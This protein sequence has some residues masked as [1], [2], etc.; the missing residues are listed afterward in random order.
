MLSFRISASASVG[1][2][3]AFAQLAIAQAPR[4][5]LP[6]THKPVPTTPA[7]SPAD[8]MTRLYTIADDSM[9]GREV[10]TEYH[11]KATAYIAAEA[12]RMGLVPAGD[13]GGY[14]QNLPV[15]S[16][17]SDSASMLGVGAERLANGPDFI[18]VTP[19]ERTVSLDGA[20]A[21]YGGVVTD[22]STWP[23]AD[24]VAGK[25]VV[26][27]ALSGV[28]IRRLAFSP[29]SRFGRATAVLV[30]AR[31]RVS[32]A[33]MVGLARSVRFARAQGAPLGP[34]SVIV[35]PR[36][37]PLL[38]G[39]MDSLKA[40]AVAMKRLTGAIVGHERPAP[41]RNVVAMLPGSDP[42][43]KGEFV[44][45]GAHNDHI[46]FNRAPVDHDSIRAF[47]RTARV[48]GADSP[49]PRSL[50]PEQLATIRRMTDS[51]R[52]LH[53]GARQDS[54]YNGAD[55]DG[56]GT[57]SVLE[58][59]E[60][61][62]KS[63]VRPKRSL[64]FIWHAAEEKGLWGAEYFTDHPTVPRDSIVA[65]LN[66]DMVGRGAASDVTGEAKDGTLT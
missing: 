14:F 33:M 5:E 58:I 11:L 37:V 26:L 6:R 54:I 23:S 38:F 30:A 28:P 43:L 41:A 31:E 12:K 56:S 63:K 49:S 59:A 51:L 35:L 57:V 3:L 46:G 13:S 15:F 18:V 2:L 66:M 17:W 7:I 64:L 61:F 39:M 25:V 8:L 9:G 50:T 19:G 47:N 60:F 45:I 55:D 62:A 42:R 34:P 44:A 48:Q 52:A 53:G 40:G 10:G 24:A 65:Q 21:I 4:G 22:S 1:A 29:T 27:S 36:V 20:T 32:P 16:S